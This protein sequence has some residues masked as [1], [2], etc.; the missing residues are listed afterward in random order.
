MRERNNLSLPWGGGCSGESRE[1]RAQLTFIGHLQESLLELYPMDDLQCYCVKLGIGRPSDLGATK[2]EL[3]R[4]I[5]AH[6][7]TTTKHTT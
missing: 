6:L 1:I 2:A 3:I 5:R 7:A 4:A